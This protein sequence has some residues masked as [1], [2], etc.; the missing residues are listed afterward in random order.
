MNV[1]CI[2]LPNGKRY[3][4]VE[5]KTGARIR[6]HRLMKTL[7][8]EYP[9]LIHLAISK[10]GWKNCRWRYLA[11][12]CTNED[13]WALERAFI[14]LFHAQDRDWGYNISEGGEH[15]S[16]GVRQD[17]NVVERRSAKLR[18][19]KQS[20]EEINNRVAARRQNGKRYTPEMIKRF[21]EGQ[22]RSFKRKDRVLI[23]PFVAGHIPWNKETI[24]VM[25][26]NSTSFKKGQQ[27]HGTPFQKGMVPWNKGQK[28]PKGSQPGPNAGKIPLPAGP[29][30]EYRWFRPEQLI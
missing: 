29:H 23:T 13:G 24:G 21:S 16:T 26:P 17:P 6:H 14:R 19:R 15:G 20:Q 25:K 22:K 2:Y 5:T 30:G 10:Y 4:G 18:G 1:Y 8:A 27:A 9:Q 12:N 7:K 28:R 3:V 11:T